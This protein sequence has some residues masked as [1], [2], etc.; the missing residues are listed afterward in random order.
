MSK[1]SMTQIGTEPQGDVEQQVRES[2]A[3]L[4]AERSFA[5]T[6]MCIL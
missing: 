6:L 2:S 1:E 4:P 5:L 3:R